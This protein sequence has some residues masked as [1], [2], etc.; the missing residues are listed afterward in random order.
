MKNTLILLFAALTFLTSCDQNADPLRNQSQPVKDAEVKETEVDPPPAIHENAMSITLLRDL[1]TLFF[2][3]GTEYSYEVNVRLYLPDLDFSAE[4][5]GD[6]PEGMT[7]ELQS[8]FNTEVVT[9]PTTLPLDPN[10]LPTTP[11]SNP[12]PTP[13]TTPTTETD[14][15][16]TPPAS[17]ANQKIYV[18]K[19]KPGF[20][21]IPDSSLSSIT[22]FVTV[23]VNI[24]TNKVRAK[25]FR[26]T[27]IQAVEKLRV[28][29]FSVTPDLREGE[30]RGQAKLYV[31]I[32]GL[33]TTRFPTLY[34][35]NTSNSSA[36]FAACANLPRSF[37]NPRTTYI[38]NP[39]DV[40]YE[41]IEYIYDV[42]LT[43]FEI[44][45][46]SNSV[47]CTFN[48]Y[49]ENQGI[50][51]NPFPATMSVLNTI[52]DP[53]TTWGESIEVEFE[54]EK[55]AQFQF[56]VF[57]QPNEGVITLNFTKPCSQVFGSEAQGDCRC[58]TNT[59]TVNRH[60][61]ECLVEANHK[62]TFNSKTYIIEFDAQMSN[63][64]LTSR[65]VN[66][67]RKIKFV[68]SG[69]SFFNIG[70]EDAT[71]PSLAPAPPIINPTG[72]R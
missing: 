37:V 70:N 57:G 60:V 64:P 45:T 29:S 56:Q 20:D 1:D 65:K 14:P 55:N 23:Q 51:S 50:A 63:G 7:L 24:G 59:T 38:T 43:R 68:P 67:K 13:T 72:P 58:R 39:N 3:E 2:E 31:K 21:A 46:N 47:S 30:K 53:R 6:V 15:E 10:A 8:E 4:L 66:F 36:T 12:N 26:Y 25:E 40:N 62:K 44:L 48:I 17:V 22:R 35:E 34:F 11:S 52:T 69:F 71:E 19:W 5:V 18:I 61:I 16:V 28:S 27:L 49:V 54:Q 42:D 33:Q 41:N 32:P 9:A